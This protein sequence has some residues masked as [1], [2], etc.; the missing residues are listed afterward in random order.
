MPK[1]EVLDVA[2][3]SFDLITASQPEARYSHGLRLITI[4]KPT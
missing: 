3:E 4:R 2:F 1:E